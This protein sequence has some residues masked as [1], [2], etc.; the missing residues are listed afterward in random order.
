M[1][2]N[3]IKKIAATMIAESM[4]TAVRDSYAKQFMNDLP[5]TYQHLLPQTA[6]QKQLKAAEGAIRQQYRDD[7]SKE[8]P[9][10]V[11]R[12][13]FLGKAPG[14][15]AMLFHQRLTEAKSALE[16][17]D[18]DAAQQLLSAAKAVGDP[19]AAATPPP[20]DVSKM[21]ATQKIQ[22][23]LR[24]ERE[25]GKG[26]TR[27]QPPIV[28]SIGAIDTSKLTAGQKIELGLRLGQ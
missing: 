16:R 26:T 14:P 3:E 1:D 2:L 4:G 20:P 6:D 23:G 15:E 12:G 27:Q 19:S 18:L 22:Y 13:L 24:Q 11:G 5:E 7:L 25:A 21:T 9:K 17:G 28:G 10:W 8:V